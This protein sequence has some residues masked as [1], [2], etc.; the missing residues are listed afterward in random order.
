MKRISNPFEIL[1]DHLAVRIEKIVEN[2]LNEFIELNKHQG[3]HSEYIPIKTLAKELG[4]SE[5][6]LRNWCQNPGS[7]FKAYR[8]KVGTERTCGVYFKRHEFEAA[9]EDR[10]PRPFHTDLDLDL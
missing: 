4:K 8:L 5:Q 2:K 7:K 9:M 3:K 6:T 1:L 10:Y